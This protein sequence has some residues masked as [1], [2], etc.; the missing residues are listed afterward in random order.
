MESDKSSLWEGEGT[1]DSLRSE[2]EKE[3]TTVVSKSGRHVTGKQKASSAKSPGGLSGKP[4]GASDAS[5]SGSTTVLQSYAEGEMKGQPLERHQSHAVVTVLGTND[6]PEK[7]LIDVGEAAI[8]VAKALKDYL[9]EA[10]MGSKG[11]SEHPSCSGPP[12]Y[13]TEPFNFEED[14]AVD[15]FK[16]MLQRVCKAEGLRFLGLKWD[17]ASETH[18]DA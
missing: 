18:E 10:S 3:P 9:V 17:R 11:N 7:N 14:R 8:K 5:T 15:L 16:E 13:I 1:S 4:Q 12:I 2:K 6:I